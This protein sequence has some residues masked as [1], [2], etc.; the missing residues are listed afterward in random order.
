[1]R[2]NLNESS[3]SPED[4]TISIEKYINDNQIRSVL[5]KIMAHFIE[6]ELKKNSSYLI[7]NFNDT[8]FL[9]KCIFIH[10]Q[11]EILF[12]KELNDFK[13][14]FTKKN[15]D[16]LT[17]KNYYLTNEYCGKI[18]NVY[19]NGIVEYCDIHK[20]THVDIKEH[21][22]VKKTKTQILKQQY[23]TNVVKLYKNYLHTVYN[24]IE[25]LHISSIA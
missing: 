5:L 8:N 9:D 17:D 19:S 16:L 18:E 1:M 2:I 22:F 11:N 25:R 23:Y 24:D 4:I 21:D 7:K 6:N 12:L 15:K 20:Y 14:D 13:E 3:P 10:S